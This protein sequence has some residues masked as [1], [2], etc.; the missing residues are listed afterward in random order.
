MPKDKNPGLPVGSRKVPIIGELNDK[1]KKVID[2]AVNGMIQKVEPMLNGLGQMVEEL[3]RRV[4][5]VEEMVSATLVDT[6]ATRVGEVLEAKS[7]IIKRK[8][9]E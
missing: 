9:K 7:R 2:T 5:V 1:D 8:E 6:I 3:G 4:A